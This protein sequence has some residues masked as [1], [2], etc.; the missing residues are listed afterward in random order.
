MSGFMCCAW[1][2]WHTRL[3]V[4]RLKVGKTGAAAAV[5]CPGAGYRA[6]QVVAHECDIAN[7]GHGVCGAPS[8]WQATVEEVAVQMHLLQ[9]GP[10]LGT[11]AAPPALK[12]HVD[13][14]S[15]RLSRYLA[16]A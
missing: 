15:Q 1:T 5:H 11:V 3:Q 10:R 16:M 13:T 12:Q 6:A 4:H 2:S 14:E 8:C 7:G 9:V